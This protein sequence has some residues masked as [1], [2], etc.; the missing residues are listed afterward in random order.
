MKLVIK[1]NAVEVAKNHGSFSYHGYLD[2][3]SRIAGTTV[4]V[5]TDFLFEDQYNIVQENLRVH[6][7]IVEEV[8]DDARTGRQRCNYCGKHSEIGHTWSFSWPGD[9]VPTLAQGDTLEIALKSI[10]GTIDTRF[11]PRTK[12]ELGPT[13]CPRCGVSGYL[14]PFK[15]FERIPDDPG[16]S[17]YDIQAETFLK[18]NNITFKA[19]LIGKKC[20]LWC[21]GKEHIHGKEHRATFRKKGSKSLSLPFWNSMIDAENGKTPTAYD[22]FSAITKNDPG[23]YEDFCSEYGLDTD[24]RT[25]EKTYKAVA[26][27]WKKVQAFFTEEEIEQLQEIQ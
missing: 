12:K 26:K 17:M 4:D 15:P 19:V 23:R 6:D 16:P 27:E 24:S 1:K 7:E 25:A 20:P 22:V 3:V 18:K 2:Y 14:V 10:Q 13:F 8:I 11:E 21:D 9:T 5:E